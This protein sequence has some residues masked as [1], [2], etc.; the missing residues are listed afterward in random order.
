MDEALKEFPI[1]EKQH[2]FQSNKGTET[3]LSNMVN[4]IEKFVFKSEMVAGVFLDISSAFDSI[5]PS[6]VKSQLLK[7][8]GDPDMVEWYFILGY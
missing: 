4:Y 1:H 8:G 6:F 3:V 7:H 2:D 5:E